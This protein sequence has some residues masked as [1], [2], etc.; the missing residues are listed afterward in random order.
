MHIRKRV[1]YVGRLMCWLC[2][3]GCPMRARWQTDRQVRARYPQHLYRCR[4]VNAPL[5]QYVRKLVRPGAG[6]LTS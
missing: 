6:A 2:S 4:I 5:S 3:T 1:S